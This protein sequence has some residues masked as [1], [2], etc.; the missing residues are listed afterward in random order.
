MIPPAGMPDSLNTFLITVALCLL[1]I[2]FSSSCRLHQSTIPEPGQ[3]P[4]AGLGLSC[5][6]RRSCGGS[7]KPSIQLA[8]QLDLAGDLE[9]DLAFASELFLVHSD[10][11]IT[12]D[13][14][15]ALPRGIAISQRI[16]G[17]AAR[18][19][20]H[21]FQVCQVFERERHCSG[22]LCGSKLSL[23]FSFLVSRFLS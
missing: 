17:I 3:F 16:G 8:I 22:R 20:C 13:W 1:V 11:V 14:P 7:D 6:L 5:L 18:P 4:F 9:L 21:C 10:T 19:T 15:R 2:F 23:G 12:T